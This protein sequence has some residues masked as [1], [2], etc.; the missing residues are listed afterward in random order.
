MDIR[1]PS[2]L[3]IKPDA[4]F[5]LGKYLRTN[6]FGR[7]TLF[8]GDGIEDLVGKSVRISLAS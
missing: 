5:K 4:L 2:L 6:G 8:Y 3:R 1:I 7:I